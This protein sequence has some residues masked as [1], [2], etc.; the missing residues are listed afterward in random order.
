[1]I[2]VFR[3]PDEARPGYFIELRFEGD[4]IRSIRDFRYVQY[5]MLDAALVLA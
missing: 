2:A 5:V 4:K 3:A 1:V